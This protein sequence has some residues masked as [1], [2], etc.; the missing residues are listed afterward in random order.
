MKLQ[1]NPN[2]AIIIFCLSKTE[3]TVS[4][5]YSLQMTLRGTTT[6]M[7]SNREEKR[8]KHM[9]GRSSGRVVVELCSESRTDNR[10]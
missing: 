5:T 2:H 8:S 1:Q 10:M 6:S 4:A 9:Y 3:R 7:R